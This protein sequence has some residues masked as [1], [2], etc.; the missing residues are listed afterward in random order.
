MK[1]SAGRTGGDRA[2]WARSRAPRPIYRKTYAL[3]SRYLT[4][5]DGVRIAI[6]V[7][8]P[9]ERRPS[10]RLPTILCQTRYHRRTVYR[11]LLERVLNFISPSRTTLGRFMCHGYA[12]VVVDV[13]GSGASFGRRRMEWAPEEVRD[14]AEVVDWIISQPWSNGRVGVS[15]ISYVGT[16]A[17]MLLRARHPA[18]K[19]ALIRFAPYDVFADI[20]SPGGVRRRRFLETWSQLIAALDGN[21]FATL[22]AAMRGRWSAIGLR[23]VAPVD[24]DRDGQMLARAM[25]EHGDNY[26]FLHN[27]MSV[28]FRDDCAP[29]GVCVDQCSP[30]TF[31]AD[32][33]A[34]SAAVY[35]WSGYYDGANTLAAIKRFLNV[36]S[37]DTRL[38]LGPWDH[39]GLQNPAASL[40]GSRSRFDEVGEILRYFDYHLKG[41][42]NGLDKDKRV[43][44]FTTGE[45]AWKAADT[46]PPEGFE[47]RWFYLAAQNRLSD[48]VPVDATGA[49]D[50][51]V[52]YS[53]G[54]GDRSRWV[55]LVNVANVRIAYSDRRER[56]A[57]LLVYES[58]PLGN[59]FELTGHPIVT[60]HVESTATDGQFFVYLEDVNSDGTVYYVTEGACRAIH[61][62]SSDEPPYTLP[63]G[64]PYRTFKRADAKPLV[65]GAP[66]EL[67]F[68]LL[69][70]S[71]L[72]K[73][74]HAI[75][76]AIAGADK[77][78]CDLV[79]AEAPRIRVLR[80][81][82][83]PSSI[84]LP[85]RSR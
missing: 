30:H 21:A 2:W 74:T 47:P 16:A 14:G 17:E 13:R 3:T 32:I 39:G 34:S 73:R 4:M 44:Y 43:H 35:S 37:R 67:T 83:Y 55:S 15:G 22:P 18:V 61:R 5:R 69:P 25:K 26:D 56:D 8:L 50:Y 29:T 57:K 63:P 27:A 6:D 28:H 77:D 36:T 49:D 78:A 76:V 70:V 84:V 19:A 54:S 20:A 66:T 65:I 71:H 42:D 51:A 58:E 48:R 11:P 68:D 80:N 60:L 59:A 33:G 79:P 85:I 53:A 41:V 38:L 64:V 12:F 52:D 40:R 9:K 24:E 45:N 82:Q 23:G 7:Y 46:W 81:R 75:R 31:A 72:F 10:D 62:A 1:R